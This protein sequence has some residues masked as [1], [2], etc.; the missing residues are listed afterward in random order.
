M[1]L[2]HK[3][4][5]LGAT[6]GRYFRG[7]FK[8]SLAGGLTTGALA[9][10]ALVVSGPIGWA[11]AA[12][13]GVSTLMGL[14]AGVLGGLG[15]GGLVAGIAGVAAAAA[16]GFASIV[17]GVGPLLAVGAVVTTMVGSGIGGG[18]ANGTFGGVRYL[19]ESVRN[20][21][22]GL[23][24]GRQRAQA[25]QLQQF[26]ELQARGVD[27]NIAAQVALASPA[28]AKPGMSPGAKVALAGAG[29]G[30]AAIGG[31]MAYNHYRK[32]DIA[33]LNA[34]AQQE[35]M[36]GLHAAGVRPLTPEQAHALREQGPDGGA[37]GRVAAQAA[38]SEPA[39]AGRV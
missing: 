18:A 39:V 34:M 16:L 4:S 21:T 35:A 25:Q 5:F 30:A 9:V 11:L 27:P 20:V 15:V 7:G 33:E 38:S 32:P 37:Q 13:A 36:Q 8:S 3:E 26:Q 17:S 10:G 1:A 22:A 2:G 31:K 29:I 6:A 23:F 19:G 14:K 28:D 12:G 24:G